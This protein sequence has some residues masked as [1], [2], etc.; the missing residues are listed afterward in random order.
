MREGEM[1]KGAKLRMLRQGAGLTQAELA[2]S[3]GVSEPAIRSYESGRKSPR[4]QT[5]ELIASMLGIASE[6]LVDY[7]AD[8]GTSVM[9]ALFDL[10]D[11][12][13]RAVPTTER[14]GSLYFEDEIIAAAVTEWAAMRSRLDS[15]ELSPAE[16]DRW[17]DSFE[18]RNL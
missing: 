6:A 8:E 15:G 11:G 14:G 1:N 13:V 5:L 10:E 12:P 7:G 17:R 3:V 9:H 18:I 2:K 4:R 16:Y